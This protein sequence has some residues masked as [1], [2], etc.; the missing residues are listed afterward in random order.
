MSY[1]VSNESKTTPK[2]VIRLIFTRTINIHE[3]IKKKNLMVKQIHS[4]FYS[5][6]KM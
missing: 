4:S 6:S 5:E 2:V 1:L 3:K